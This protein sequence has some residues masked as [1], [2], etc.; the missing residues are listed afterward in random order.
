MP[1]YR[2]PHSLLWLQCQWWRKCP[3]PLLDMI[4]GHMTRMISR[5]R[6]Y[7][8]YEI[9][10]RLTFWLGKR[11]TRV[12]FYICFLL[13]LT[14]TSYSRH[15]WAFIQRSFQYPRILPN[16]NLSIYELCI[17]EACS[18]MDRDSDTKDLHR[19]QKRRRLL[20][21]PVPFNDCRYT[22]SCATI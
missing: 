6:N 16:E 12:V 8:M 7:A 18:Y 19:N 14:S 2:Y 3:L 21:L 20:D 4:V 22:F 13:S 10:P 15:P 11:R 5:I 9:F 17:R 1:N